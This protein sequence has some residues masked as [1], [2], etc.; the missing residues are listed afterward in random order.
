MFISYQKHIVALDIRIYPREYDFLIEPS[1]KL[2]LLESLSVVLE[3]S[4]EAFI[5]RHASTLKKLCLTNQSGLD[6]LEVPALPC[7]ESLIVDRLH[8]ETV[9]SLFRASKQTITSLDIRDVD[10]N[11]HP[12]INNNNEATSVYQFPNLQT[13][14]IY[15]SDCTQL[16]THNASNITSLTLNIFDIPSELPELPKLRELTILDFLHDSHIF[17]KCKKSLKCLVLNGISFDDNAVDLP[18]LTDLYI[19][20]R[21]IDALRYLD[22]RKTCGK[23]ISYNSKSLKFVLLQ[24]VDPDMITLDDNVK[25]KGIKIVILK[26]L[27]GDYAYNE[28]ERARM[29]ELCP[30]AEIFIWSSQNMDVMHNFVKSHRTNRGFSTDGDFLSCPTLYDMYSLD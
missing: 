19:L 25:L 27:Y 7:L 8:T 20:G 13:L 15:K 1:M 9:W 30:N 10:V 22:S 14:V 21:H 23:F 18:Q 5:F 29:A 17:S 28:K 26:H 24:N 12:A 4:T 16:L 3:R 2:D 11:T 6:N